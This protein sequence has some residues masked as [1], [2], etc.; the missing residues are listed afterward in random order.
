VSEEHRRC[1]YADGCGVGGCWATQHM[2]NEPKVGIANLRLCALLSLRSIT[3]ASLFQD[4]CFAGEIS[5]APVDVH[6][7]VALN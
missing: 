5:G 6:L 3:P 4:R 7:R 1:P 2:R